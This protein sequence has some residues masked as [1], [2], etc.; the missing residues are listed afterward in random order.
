MKVG[1]FEVFLRMIANN[2]KALQLAPLTNITEARAVKAGTCGCGL[3]CRSSSILWRVCCN[4]YH[5]R[6]RGRGMTAVQQFRR[7]LS[8]LYVQVPEEVGDSIVKYADAALE[9]ERA[10]GRS[11]MAKEA[12]ELADGMIGATRHEIAAAILKRK[13]GS[14]P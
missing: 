13:E 5:I 1:A 11:A 3:R 4:K 10:A 7:A 6:N 2:D 8:A 14:K 9:E 12:A